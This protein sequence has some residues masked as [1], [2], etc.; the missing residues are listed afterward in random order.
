[1]AQSGRAEHITL[2]SAVEGKAD[3]ICSVRAF[4]M[5]V[6]GLSDCRKYRDP[7]Q[8]GFAWGSRTLVRRRGQK[9]VSPI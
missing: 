5:A 4:P 2:M 3:S 6:I 1:M 7:D 9:G 8:S